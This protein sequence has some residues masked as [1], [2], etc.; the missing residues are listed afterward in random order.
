MSIFRGGFDDVIGASI[1]DQSISYQTV[2]LHQPNT[3]PLT[4]AKYSLK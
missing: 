3:D 1:S 2:Q 4:G